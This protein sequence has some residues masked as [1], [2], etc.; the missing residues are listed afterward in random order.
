VIAEPTAGSIVTK[1]AGAL[2]F[3]LEVPGRAAHGAMRDQGVS[4]VERFAE[5]HA[6]LRA[7]EAERQVGADRAL[8]G[9]RYP[10]GL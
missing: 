8:F 1:N 5:L 2:T 7:L 4:A 9:T 3:R 6:E 10:Y